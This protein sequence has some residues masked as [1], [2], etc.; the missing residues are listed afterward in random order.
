MGVGGVVTFKNAVEIKK[1]AKEIE[2][3]HILSETDCPYLAPTPYRGK[4]NE[5]A[6]VKYVVE[7]IAKIR[8]ESIDD[9][10]GCLEANA[11]KLFRL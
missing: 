5:P 8:G 3:T 6:Y 4:R 7:E 1:I 2:L 9:V 11:K 10:E